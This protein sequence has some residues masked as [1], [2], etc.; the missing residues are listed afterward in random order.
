MY[1]VPE[2]IYDEAVAVFEKNEKIEEFFSDTH[3]FLECIETEKKLIKS[4]LKNF[5]AHNAHED[6]A[7]KQHEKFYTNVEFP[8]TILIKYINIFKK[9]VLVDIQK[10][11]EDAPLCQEEISDFSFRIET[12]VNL[13]S[14]NYIRKESLH[15][16]KFAKSKFENFQLFYLHINWVNSIMD[17]I[18]KDNKYAFPKTNAKNCS[19]SQIINYPESLMV[20]LDASL[21]NQLEVLHEL[22]HQQASTFYRLYA[23]EEFVQAYFLLKEFLESVQ[24]FLSLLKDLYYLSHS[25]LENSFFKLIDSLSYTDSNIILSL[26]DIKELKRLNN[27][28]GEKKVDEVIDEIELILQTDAKKSPQDTLIIRGVSANFYLLHLNQGESKVFKEKI[29]QLKAFIQTK[30]AKKHP[31][32]APEINIAS[33]AFDKQIKYNKDELI[34]IMLHLKEQS[35]KSGHDTFIFLDK[36]KKALRK[37]LNDHY[38]NIQYIQDKIRDK[39]VDVVLQPI[40]KANSE[41]MF[42]VEALARIKDKGKLLPAGMFIDTLYE[43]NLITQLDTLVLD[44]IMQKKEYILEKDIYVFINSAA[45]SLSDDTYIAKLYEFLENF[46]SKHV[47]IEVTEQQALKNI[48]VL[49]KVYEKTGVKFAIDDFGT[50]YSALK[51]VSEMAEAGLLQTLKIDGSLIMNLDKEKQTQKIIQVIGKMCETFEIFSLGEF[52][53]NQETLN[54]LKEFNINLAQ[55]YHLAKPLQIEEL[56][57]L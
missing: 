51:T 35:K 12:L 28:Y 46:S 3:S 45:A 13:I 31:E 14:F 39:E 4:Y 1:Q 10:S 22:I 55:G 25:D 43:I 41:E 40:F 32:F 52:V 36:E 50:G 21:C 53:E 42:A 30:L 20:C 29:Y 24:K 8:Y 6:E 57:V 37:W 16:K 33:F 48:D 54:L 34:R 15:F 9:L 23:R 7:R 49:Q 19:Y 47:I 38:F 17:A 27:L 26:V 56:Y 18:L 44:A 2:K 11:I 5:D